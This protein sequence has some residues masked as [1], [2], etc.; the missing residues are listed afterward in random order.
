MLCKKL[1]Q[2]L[3]SIM[4]RKII[5]D[6]IIF[7]VDGTL[8]DASENL[9]KAWTG[10]VQSFGIEEEISVK[11]IGDIEVGFCSEGSL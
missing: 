10:T 4:E 9:A 5:A 3:R 6:G 7:D 11:D 8:W 1:V 2:K